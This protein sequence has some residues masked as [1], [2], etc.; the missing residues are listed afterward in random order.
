[1]DM[2]DGADRAE[3]PATGSSLAFPAVARLEL[4]ELLDQLIERAQ[5]VKGTQG[6]LRGL[7]AATAHVGAGL[8]LEELLRR[9]VEAARALVGAR[10]AALGL[11]RGGRLVEFV[12]TGMSAAQVEA[13]GDLPVGKGL[14]GELIEH[15]RPLRL[16]D[17]QGHPA[18]AG[19]PAGHPPMGAFLGVPVRV[20]ET[21]YGNLY[22]TESRDAEGFSAEDEELAV[23]LAAAAGLAVENALLLVEARRGERWQAAAAEIT[24][25]LIP[26]PSSA[27]DLAAAGQLLVEAAA[28]VADADGAAL[29]TVEA[30]D[31][32]VARVHAAC[33]A[34]ADWA[35][36][37]TPIESITQVALTQHSPVVVADAT[38][39]PR[40]A[41][42][43]D[44]APEL[45][46]L[47]AAPLVGAGG[48][49]QSVLTLVR[50][51]ER[52]P[53]S[54][55][56]RTMIRG[57]AAHTGVALAVVAA[58]AEH[59]RRHRTSN[60]EQLIT[61]LGT[62]VLRRLARVNLELTNL[63]EHLSGPARRAALQRADDIDQLLRHVHDAI[64]DL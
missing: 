30:A 8:E 45:G 36:H 42:M 4:D 47:I 41:G 56:D 34:V 9:I 5:E 16:T 52:E 61:N 20:G 26:G 35:G 15:P 54:D 10:Y 44:R 11:V 57:F 60:R 1:M 27:A 38:S 59:E 33:G 46:V 31:P 32:S 37:P 43:V 62:L 14:L 58:R 17:L 7:L 6:R 48:S 24:R 28:E 51:R 13:I 55:L 49:G 18:A 2:W 63:A 23:A 64:D 12:H 22:L 50:Y 3:P 40:A 29:S 21:V 25:A 19:F 39:D 53:F